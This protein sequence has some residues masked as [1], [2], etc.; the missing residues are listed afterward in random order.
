MSLKS[1]IHSV[2]RE[3]DAKD[4]AGEELFGDSR[5]KAEPDSR[6]HEKELDRDIKA[7]YGGHLP[8][9]T[10]DD[11]N[12]LQKL[13]SSGEYDDVL[14]PPSGMAYRFMNM[15]WANA[16]SRFSLTRLDETNGGD[17]D[18]VIE[19]W[20][21]APFKLNLKRKNRGHWKTN[22][23]AASWTVDPDVLRQISNDW[24]RLLKPYSKK[25]DCLAFFKAPI[26]DQSF[27][28]NPDEMGSLAGRYEY[29][30][31]V[32]QIAPVQV[33]EGLLY[34]WANRSQWEKPWGGVSPIS[35]GEFDAAV[36]ADLDTR[37]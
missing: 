36:L 25:L 31:E 9:L 28:F 27:L 12:L 35:A 1:Y 26:T 5:G 6:P 3:F 19:I 21:I 29:Q 18:I 8:S 16:K 7:W 23:N 2:L 14:A 32:I 34:R 30:K 15:A 4:I 11:I 17:G 37:F 10:S 13:K 24:G 22:V 33:S 20:S